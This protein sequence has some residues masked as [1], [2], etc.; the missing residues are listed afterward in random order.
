MG[1]SDGD[2]SKDGNEG[3]KGN[4]KALELLKSSYQE[5]SESSSH[6]DDEGG[7]EA[8]KVGSKR[9]HGQMSGEVVATEGDKRSKDE[10]ENPE[11]KN[12]QEK[13]SNQSDQ[14]DESGESESL[15]SEQERIR[16]EEQLHQEII[17]L[18]LKKNEPLTP[19]QISYQLRT[20]KRFIDESL[21]QLINENRVSKAQLVKNS[22][23]Y[24]I[25][26]KEQLRLQ[27]PDSNSD[28]LT[29]SLILIQQAQTDLVSAHAPSTKE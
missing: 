1:K 15:D 11:V 21:N 24:Y 7:K 8:V 25:P 6:T 2:G 3:C 26:L 17:D 9:T 27:N 28:A 16:A 18:L 22:I 12:G 29:E 20:S 10:C 14:D 23:L 4:G 19:Q 13:Q 5:T